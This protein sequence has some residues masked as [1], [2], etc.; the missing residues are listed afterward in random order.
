MGGVRQKICD[1]KR[2]LLE[3]A[4]H[5]PQE[6]AKRSREYRKETT[7]PSLVELMDSGSPGFNVQEVE[8]CPIES[9]VGG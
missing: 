3:V 2:I 8:T 9:K 4:K 5:F 7:E 6:R 1:S